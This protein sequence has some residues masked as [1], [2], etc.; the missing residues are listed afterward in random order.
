MKTCAVHGTVLAPRQRCPLC[1]RDGIG[2]QS[3]H[4]RAWRRYSHLILRQRPLCE[5]C[6]QTGL[7]VPA[8]EVHHIRDRADGGALFP[9]DEGVEALCKRCHAK[10]T[11]SSK[12][13]LTQLSHRGEGRSREKTVHVGTR[14]RQPQEKP[15]FPVPREIPIRCRSFTGADFAAVLRLKRLSDH[16][17]ASS[18]HEGRLPDHTE[19]ANH[20]STAHHLTCQR[21]GCRRPF[22]ATRS[23]AKFCSRRCRR[24]KRV[25]APSAAAM[26]PAVD[27]GAEPPAVVDKED[28]GGWRRV[29]PFLIP[30]PDP[31]NTFRVDS[32]R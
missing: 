7:T 2:T 26:S 28:L 4:T 23:D 20:M 15:N 5:R 19:G 10:D 8:T 27:I 32:L 12:S 14:T 25:S 3:R 31:R 11:A 21:P 24:S 13:G 18:D 6:K 1:H 22:A 29:G 17:G 16:T 9:G 30:P